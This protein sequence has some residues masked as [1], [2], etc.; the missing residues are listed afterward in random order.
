MPAASARIL[1]ELLYLQPYTTSEVHKL[2]DTDREVRLN[3]VK[4]YLHASYD[5][6]IDPSVLRTK[7]LSCGISEL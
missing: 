1:T 7:R 2:Y 3:F 6:E 4:W 5:V